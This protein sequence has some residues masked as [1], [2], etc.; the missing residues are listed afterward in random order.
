MLQ[1]TILQISTKLNLSLCALV[2]LKDS[3]STKSDFSFC[4]LLSFT[5]VLNFMKE[6]CHCHKRPFRHKVFVRPSK[7]KTFGNTKEKIYRSADVRRG[8]VPTHGYASSSFP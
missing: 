6:L 1:F 3:W 8:Y 2:Y 7:E 4:C 5:F